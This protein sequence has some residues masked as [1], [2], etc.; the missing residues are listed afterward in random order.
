MQW[1]KSEIW[2]P[3]YS[4][5]DR[6]TLFSDWSIIIKPAGLCLTN[7]IMHGSGEKLCCIHIV[8][9]YIA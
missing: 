2:S 1:N 4:L 8:E 3:D 5:H 7:K 6:I 9:K